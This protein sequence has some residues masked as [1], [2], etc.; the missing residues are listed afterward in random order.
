MSAVQA[1]T[2]GHDCETTTWLVLRCPSS[3]TIAL[4]RALGDN[5]DE[6]RRY[7]NIGAWTPTWRRKRRLPRSSI[8][9]LIELPCIPS[10]VFVPDIGAPLPM[11][12]HIPFTLMQRPDS[13]RLVRVRDR[14]LEALRKAADK[15]MIKARDLPKAG[16]IVHFTGAAFGGLKG[17]ILKCNATYCEVDVEGFA[18]PFK[19]AP[20]LIQRM[21]A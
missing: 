2:F 16:T 8:S 21:A 10:M 3:K 18:Q 1:E 14:E 19:I 7:P 15:P 13:G 11:I 4:A 17:K 9:R 20:S 6:K 12:P 5:D